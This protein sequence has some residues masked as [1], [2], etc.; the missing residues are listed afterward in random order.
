MVGSTE[1]LIRHVSIPHN[2]K[3]VYMG[4]FSR[5][6][7]FLFPALLGFFFML[8]GTN[9]FSALFPHR[10]FFGAGVYFPLLFMFVGLVLMIASIY[11]WYALPFRSI[12]LLT[13]G[14]IYV[15]L[16]FYL[17]KKQERIPLKSI[18]TLG[19]PQ[20]QYIGPLEEVQEAYSKLLELLQNP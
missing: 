12:L 6:L 14:A 20:P 17:Y 13:N 8:I 16:D 2:E 9:V 3:I 7:I 15:Y 1:E 10:D 18:Q 4:R 5:G 11:L 19:S